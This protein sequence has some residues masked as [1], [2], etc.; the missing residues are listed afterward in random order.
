[1]KQNSLSK[2]VAFE[3]IGTII[4]IGTIKNYRNY[5]TTIVAIKL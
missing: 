3:N 1:M 4:T 5:K 2:A